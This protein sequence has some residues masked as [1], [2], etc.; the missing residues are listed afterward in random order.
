MLGAKPFDVVTFLLAIS[1]GAGWQ[2]TYGP[3]V[4]D[5]SR[6]LPADTPT[7]RSFRSTFLCS[8]LGSQLSMTVGALIAAVPAGADKSKGFLA[9]QVGFIGDLAGGGG[10]ALLIYVVIVTGKL[11]VNCLNAYGGSMTLL[12][13]TSAFR[14]DA[15]VTTAARTAYIVG[16]LVVSVLL[17]LLASADFLSNFKNFVLVLLMVFTPWSAVNLVDYYLISREKV[18][19]PALYDPDGRYGRWNAPA[20]TAYVVAI[21]AQVPFLAQSLY[22]G[23]VTGW[24]G[25]RTSRGSSGSSSPGRSTTPGPAGRAELPMRWSTPPAR[26]SGT[27]RALRSVADGRGRPCSTA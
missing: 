24:L 17:A 10:I 12:T 11:T 1:L 2:L 16:F 3:Y 14:R 9:N 21:V 22:T 26:A 15:R 23:P 19:I 25:A 8:V 5:Y 13:T 6:Y 18:D 7:A 4:A 20:L 27:R